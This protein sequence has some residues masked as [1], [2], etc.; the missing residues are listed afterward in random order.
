VRKGSV[1]WTKKYADRDGVTMQ[2]NI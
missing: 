1:G 2:E